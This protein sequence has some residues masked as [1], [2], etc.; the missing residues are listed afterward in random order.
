MKGGATNIKSI[1]P[2]HY[3]IQKGGNRLKK[4]M[5]LFHKTLPKMKFSH[6]RKTSRNKSK[7]ETKRA[8]YSKL[9]DNK[10]KSRKRK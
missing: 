4:T 10:K 7:G 5:K 3:K 9:S 1:M 8:K 2:I 6:L